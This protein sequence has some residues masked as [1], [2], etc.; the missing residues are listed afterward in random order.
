MN[1][2]YFAKFRY[3]SI[4]LQLH[5]PAFY[6]CQQVIAG[7]INYA[8]KKETFIARI[9]TNLMLVANL[10]DAIGSNIIDIIQNI[11]KLQQKKFFFNFLKLQF[12]LIIFEFKLKFY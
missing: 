8:F 2:K 7:K 6:S 1:Y 11:L 3:K 5:S 10:I 12:K 9:E 4:I